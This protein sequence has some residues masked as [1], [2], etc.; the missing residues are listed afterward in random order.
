MKKVQR[1]FAVEY[2]SGRRKLNSKPNSIW[3]NVDLKSVARDL[4][5]EAS[6]FL[7]ATSQVTSSETAFAGEQQA[8][9]LLTPPIEQETNAS[10]LRETTMADGNDT[11]T[12]V[13]TPATAAPDVVKKERKPRVKKAAAETVSAAV[14]AQ[15][16]PNA[17]AVK[18]KRGRKAAKSDE[19]ATSAK[20]AP[21]KRAP[22]AVQAAAAPSVAAVDEFADLLRLEEENQRL[23][24]LLAEKLRTENADLRKRLNLG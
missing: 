17:T 16:A 9:A 20:R 10:A 7:A 3:G 21:V 22:K 12:D 14:S 13:E 8:A 23:R 18:P 11:M 6:P 24:K 2:R 4:Q 1:S 19:A 15:P 5:D